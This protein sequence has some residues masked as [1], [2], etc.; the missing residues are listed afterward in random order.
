[1]TRSLV[2]AA[3]LA[4]CTTS[5]DGTSTPPGGGS[6]PGS[7]DGSDDG[8]DAGTPGNGIPATIRISGT[9]AEQGQSAA[10]PLAGV[11]ISAFRAG[12][13]T[14]PVATATT[15]A[16]GAYALSIPTNGAP[17]E[18]YLKATKSGEVDAYVYPPIAMTADY[19]SATVGMVSTS[20]FNLLRQFEGAQ[21]GKGVI[22]LVVLDATA[23]NAIQGATASS[24][25]AA[26]KTMYMD[27]SGQPFATGS[28]NS[29][30]LAFLFNVQ[31]GADITV[32]AT[33]GGTSFTSH[34]V[35][36]RPDAMTTTMVLSQ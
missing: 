30:G 22:V 28:T 4:A 7:N 6:N 19:A 31:P 27:N 9:A 34:V 8:P 13:D 24:S 5:I 25:P 20:N 16:S 10:T 35:Q 2:F 23:T 11:A 26:G 18:G 1:M 32:G 29:D 14:T 33:K 17:V 12:D 3:M 36:A 21:N 15:D